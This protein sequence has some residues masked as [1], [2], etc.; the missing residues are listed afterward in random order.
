MKR[1]MN[2]KLLSQIEAGEDISAPIVQIVPRGWA[3]LQRNVLICLRNG[4]MGRTQMHHKIVLRVPTKKCGGNAVSVAMSGKHPPTIGFAEVAAQ[5]ARENS[6]ASLLS[7]HD[8]LSR[9]PAYA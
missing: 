3:A 8:S 9:K 5:F 2:G 4:I 1:G 6:V 7:T